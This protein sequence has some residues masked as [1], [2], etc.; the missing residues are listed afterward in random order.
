MTP[1]PQ[2]SRPPSPPPA[3]VAVMK[4]P[5][6]YFNF[7]PLLRHFQRFEREIFGV[8]LLRWRAFRRW[9]LT[10]QPVRETRDVL[11]RRRLGWRS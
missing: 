5:C 9:C 7:A 8:R 1:L 3:G 6:Q 2:R 4:L 11:R 10:Y